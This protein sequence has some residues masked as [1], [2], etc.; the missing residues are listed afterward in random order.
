MSKFEVYK[1][2]KG[3]YRWRLLAGNGQIIASSEGY[4]TKQACLDGIDSVKKNAPTAAV[5]EKA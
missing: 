2:A 1:D 4:S 5:E 3:E